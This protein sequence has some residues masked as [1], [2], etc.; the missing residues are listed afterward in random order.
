MLTILHNY[1]VKDSMEDKANHKNPAA[2]IKVRHT[3]NDVLLF[4]YFDAAQMEFQASNGNLFHV[5]EHVTQPAITLKF[6]RNHGQEGTL[7]VAL[8]DFRKL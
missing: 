7:C 2:L 4:L 6:H 3:Y 1:H 5:F 8:L